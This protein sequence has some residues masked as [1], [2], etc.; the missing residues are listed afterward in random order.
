MSLYI[1]LTKLVAGAI[2]FDGGSISLV[3]S[4]DQGGC[5]QFKLNRKI[6]ERDTPAFNRVTSDTLQ[7]DD[8]ETQQLSLQLQRVLATTEPTHDCYALLSTFV[9]HL[10]GSESAPSSTE[11][12]TRIECADSLKAIYKE[13]MS[14]PTVMDLSLE[15]QFCHRLCAI[16]EETLLT[17]MDLIV[18]IFDR[19]HE[20]HTDTFY[21]VKLKEQC[22]FFVDWANAAASNPN[23]KCNSREFS[24][25][26]DVF[27]CVPE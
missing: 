12:P 20:S 14:A 13:I 25:I 16:D 15:L 3:I 17:C 9:T 2:A 7:L 26:A 19:L 8:S 23:F 5:A 27:S 22:A 10:V 18:K 24:S 1:D 21:E 4:D 11:G 6:S